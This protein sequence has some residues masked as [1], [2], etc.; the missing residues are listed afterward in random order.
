MRWI[1]TAVLMCG[2]TGCQWATAPDEAMHAAHLE[3]YAAQAAR[4]KLDAVLLIKARE[5]G[6][7]K[8]SIQEKYTT[9]QLRNVQLKYPT[10]MPSDVAMKLLAEVRERDADLAKSRSDWAAILAAWRD[11]NTLSVE[12]VAAAKA[13]EISWQ[14]FKRS[15]AAMRDSAIRTI[16]GLA[17][18]VVTGFA[19]Q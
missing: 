11:G 5:M 18:G 17:A 3:W 7:K 8:H 16:G 2:L 10:T 1:V 15:A 4:N 19:V 9:E 14:A 6:D 12:A 13:D